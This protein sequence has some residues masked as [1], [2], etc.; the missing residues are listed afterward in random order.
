MY[1]Y[2]NLQTRSEGVTP[3]YSN[4]CNLGTSLH[5]CFPKL[6]CFVIINLY[7]NTPFK[8]LITWYKSILIP[9][10]PTR[11]L[12]K[13]HSHTCIIYLGSTTC[14]ISPICYVEVLLD[15]AHSCVVSM[16][17]VVADELGIESNYNIVRPRTLWVGFQPRLYT[18]PMG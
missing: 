7:K 15:V 14:I 16:G 10:Y 17:V 13:T 2:F 18:F 8:S 6:I 12:Y 9:L 5:L 4:G 11:I 3:Y 1:G